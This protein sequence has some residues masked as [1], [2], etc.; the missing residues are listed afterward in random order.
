MA[1][2]AQ[3]ADAL[4]RLWSGTQ[5]PAEDPPAA[6]VLRIVAI[7]LLPD[8]G[9]FKGEPYV[10]EPTARF[11]LTLTLDGKPGRYEFEHPLVELKRYE[12]PEEA[13]R[14]LGSVAILSPLMQW[15]SGKDFG[16]LGPQL[17]EDREQTS[18]GVSGRS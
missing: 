8:Q 10:N 6:P 4:D 15:W 7:R 1:T 18:P 5:L 9:V 17:I 12:D 2:P 16:E 3:V 14:F 11:E 13:A